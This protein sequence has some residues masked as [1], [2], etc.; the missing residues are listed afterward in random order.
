LGSQN[1]GIL[2][3]LLPLGGAHSDPQGSNNSQ[4]GA[5]ELDELSQMNEQQRREMRYQNFATLV[6]LLKFH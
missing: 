3:H 6:F 4:A 2:D 1:L 5:A